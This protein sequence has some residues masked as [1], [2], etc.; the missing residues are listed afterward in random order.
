MFKLKMIKK[1]ILFKLK[2]DFTFPPIVLANMQEKEA[3][4]TKE[5]QEIVPDKN[6]DGLSKVTVQKIPT[7][8]IIPSGNIQI[9]ENGTY[10][11]TS[12][13]SVNVDVQPN[14]QI[15]S[16]TPTTSSQNI[17]A[18][19]GYNGLSSVSISAVDSSIDSNIVSSNIK[20]GVSILGVTGTLNEGITPSGELAITENGT[21]DV[22]NYASA[23]VNVSSGGSSAKIKPTSI[24]FS[25]STEETIDLSNIDMSIITRANSM[26]YNC[27]NLKTILGIDTSNVTSMYNTFGNCSNL[28][29]IPQLN[30]S[31]VTTMESLFKE[32][33]SLTAIPEMDTSKVNRM[34]STFYYCTKITTIPEID[35]SN[36]TRM[37]YLF[38][39]CKSLTT[40][41]EMVANNVVRVDSMYIDCNSLTNLGGLLNIGQSYSTSYSA[42]NSDYKLNLSAC[43]L[44][45]EQSL[46]NMLNGL[47]DIAT[48]G[49]NVQS[50]VLGSTNLAK[51]TSEEGQQ[52][53]TQ[54]QNYG[55]TV[56]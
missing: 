49:C 20:N 48:K 41:P 55:W 24:S 28:L 11:I 42:N 15:K 26:F 37:D 23:N 21:Y 25:G 46:I 2:C 45:T 32:C 6:Y 56:A 44:L 12:K 34:D 31:K 39:A 54:A 53:L 4:P 30:T 47:Y 18:D 14:L 22:T 17:T 27:S 29:E 38:G 8:Y 52:A 3:I 16:A 10:D 7:K 50:I 51:L 19:E 43:T 9:T 36:V 1:P 40:I 13:E 5:Q 33:R 35:T